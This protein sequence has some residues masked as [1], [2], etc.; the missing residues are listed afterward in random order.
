M[1]K[2]L[3][4]ATTAIAIAAAGGLAYA[5]SGGTA[6]EANNNGVPGVEVNVG[7]NA[8]NDGGLPGVETNIGADGDQRNLGTN[9]MGAGSSDMNS[10][11]NDTST[12][13]AGND[14]SSD[15]YQPR[16]DRN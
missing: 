16:A 15:L 4:S 10:T 12:L 7:D 6:Q 2:R 13:G 11:T 1:N 5:Q 8:R 14:T 9:T 3:I